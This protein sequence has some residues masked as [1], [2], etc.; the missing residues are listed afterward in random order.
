MTVEN[1]HD[2]I[3]RVI[4]EQLPLR[5][6]ILD[7]QEKIIG[8]LEPLA[9][10][11]LQNDEVLHALTQWRNQ[12]Q[13]FFLTQFSA[14]FERTKNWLVN[15]VFRDCSRLLFLIHSTSKLIGQYGFKNLSP[16]SVELDNLIRGEIGGHPRLIYYAETALVRWLFETFTLESIYAVVLV[17]N[18]MAI[19]L[20][21]E[22]GFRNIENIPLY[23]TRVNDD[24]HLSI[25]Q[26]GEFGQ[27][28]IYAQR[29]RLLLSDFILM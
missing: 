19:N 16:D 18:A 29:M 28:A 12:S 3:C 2:F 9:V 25:K 24:I 20:H 8:Y 6:D 17:K 4:Q 22:I 26:N 15:T 13:Q 27:T 7:T 21:H 5:I 14:T 1:S 10:S 23:E 11:V